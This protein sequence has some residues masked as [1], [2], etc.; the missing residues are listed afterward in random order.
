MTSVKKKIKTIE[1]GGKNYFVNNVPAQFEK[2]PEWLLAQNR[3]NVVFSKHFDET[4]E[5]AA[6]MRSWFSGK[7]PTEQQ[8]RRA[9]I[10]G[11]DSFGD[12]SIKSGGG[13]IADSIFISHFKMTVE[14]KR[15]GFDKD[16]V[17]LKKYSN[18]FE[19]VLITPDELQ[20]LQE[21]TESKQAKNVRRLRLLPSMLREIIRYEKG[22]TS[23]GN[24]KNW[25]EKDINCM[26]SQIRRDYTSAEFHECLQRMVNYAANFENRS[27]IGGTG[28]DFLNFIA[29]RIFSDQTET[30]IIQL[31]TPF[32]T[33]AQLPE[34]IPTMPFQQTLFQF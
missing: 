23:M 2:Q 4:T 7:Q 17:V 22:I 32:I 5:P 8:V 28:Q 24:G 26:R 29:D 30:K 34:I 3:V 16:V 9:L 25:T 1:I 18:N 10:W 14:D 15:T 27:L 20:Q 12:Y 19:D 31:K 33:S 21:A 13:A 6:E 11:F